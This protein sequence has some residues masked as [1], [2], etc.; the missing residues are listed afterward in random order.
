MSIV[1]LNNRGVKNATA[2]GSITG[3]GSMK[4][5]KKL[6]A[7]SSATLSF[8]DGASGVVLDNTYKEYLFTF[9][10]I[11]PSTASELSFNLS[12]DSGSNY[13]VTKTST[14]FTAG[15]NEADSDAYVVY[16]T[17]RDLAQGTGFQEFTANIGTDNDGSANGYLHLFNPSSTT[18][19]KHFMS[20]VNY[21]EQSTYS[22]E[23][24]IAGYGNTTS[25]VDAVQFKFVSGNIDAGDICLY[26]IA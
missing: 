17:S 15:H 8:V 6:T 13:N 5:I 14:A 11:H 26:G 16:N 3:L 1:K 18:F 12:I 2:F 20:R 19:V 7:S 24:Y 9:K 4:F 23:H 25:A 21:N 10:N 22:N